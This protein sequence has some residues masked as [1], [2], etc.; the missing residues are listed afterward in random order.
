MRIIE[1][2]RSGVS[3]LV[4]KA[5]C[6]DHYSSTY[7][8]LFDVGCLLLVIKATCIYRKYRCI[9]CEQGTYECIVY[10]VYSTTCVHE[11][12]WNGPIIFM[13]IICMANLL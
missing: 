3:P 6:T 7:S 12:L 1:E 8:K 2:N 9:L 11:G 5:M 4:T 13:V 10:C